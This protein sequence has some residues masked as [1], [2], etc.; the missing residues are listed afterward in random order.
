M[1][2]TK[3]RRLLEEYG[4]FETLNGKWYDGHG[5]FISRWTSYKKVKLIL[6]VE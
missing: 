3:K 1:F 2:V 4:Y 6:G 5:G